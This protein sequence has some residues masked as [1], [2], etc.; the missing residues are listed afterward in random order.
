MRRIE[1]YTADYCPHCR[2]AEALLG[3]EPD[4][5]FINCMECPTLAKRRRIEKLPTLIYYVDNTEAGRTVGVT[6]N[7]IPWLRG[8]CD[9]FS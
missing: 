7:T 3:S 5:T 6:K 8:E 1:V 4:V 9:D 2:Q